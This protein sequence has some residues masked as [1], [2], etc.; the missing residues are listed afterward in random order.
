MLPPAHRLVFRPGAAARR[1][2]LL[3]ASRSRRERPRSDESEVV[4]ELLARMR[5]AVRA[6]ADVRRAG[7]LLPQRRDR[8]VADDG[9]GR[10]ESRRP[11]KTFTLTYAGG[12]TTAGQ[13]TGPALGALGRRALRHRASRGDDRRLATIP[14]SIRKILR[15]F[16]EPFAGVVSTYFLSQRMAQHV[17]VRRRRRRRRRTVRQLSVASHRGR[18]ASGRPAGASAADPDWAWRA[19]CS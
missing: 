18:H 11:I 4:E 6:P 3:A 9:A 14:S 8:F 13:G 2:A 5:R 17:K 16:D 7:R 1:L 15:A 12:S 19:D 10:R